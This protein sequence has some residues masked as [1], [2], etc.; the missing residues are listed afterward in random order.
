MSFGDRT[1][2]RPSP[3][4]W[5]RSTRWK[6]L[7]ELGVRQVS[8]GDTIGVANPLQVRRVLHEVLAVAPA[9]TLAMHFHDTRGTALANITVGLELGL[10]TIDS[11]V[12]GLGGC[13]YAPGAA[14]NVSTEDVVNML[15]GMGIETGIDMAKLAGAT[16]LVSAHVDHELS[17]KMLK[18]YLGD[19]IRA[20]RQAAR[21][22]A[23]EGAEKATKE[24]S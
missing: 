5:P 2:T 8:L 17:S 13:P 20:K 10:T 12:G 1:S 23:A 21:A 16:R 18:A 9:D 24:A 6:Q 3:R 22:A 14:G 15:H 7:L 4:R 19:Q 11:A